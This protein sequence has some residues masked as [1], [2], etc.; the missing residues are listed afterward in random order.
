MRKGLTGKFLRLLLQRPAASP[1]EVQIEITNRCN[2]NCAV[3]Q[4]HTMK[5]LAEKDMPYDFFC[6]VIA[7]LPRVPWLILTGWGEPLIHPRFS[8]CVKRARAVMPHTKIRFTTNGFLLDENRFAVL[9]AC[10][11]V[12]RITFS[13]E[14]LDG[15]PG[16]GHMPREKVVRHIRHACAQKPAGMEIILQ[17][18]LEKGHIPRI[19]QLIDFGKAS[20][21][22]GLNLVRLDRNTAH[23]VRPSHQTEKR[24]IDDL[25]V[26]SRRAG[27]PLYSANR[28]NFWV[29][30][31]THQDRWC[32]RLDDYLYIDVDG[33]AAPCCSRRNYHL[34]NIVIE[35]WAS[36]WNGPQLKAFRAAQVK[37]CKTCDSLFYHYKK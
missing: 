26:Y 15:D 34:G 7:R 10:G 8:D 17:T 33:N 12:A 36:I 27:F 2:F 30:L 28:K 23:G 31:A 37:V 35:D 16:G 3:C 29:Q 22:D 4:R 5:G 9:A 25:F 1:R 19:K 13:I 18:L 20:G 14:S 11:N 21:A 6:R 24:M 32:P